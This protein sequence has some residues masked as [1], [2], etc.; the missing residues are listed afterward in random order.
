[1][2]AHPLMSQAMRNQGREWSAV[3]TS[4]KA[5]ATVDA[6]DEVIAANDAPETGRPYTGPTNPAK[7]DAAKKATAPARRRATKTTPPEADAPA[8]VAPPV[9][10]YK[11]KAF[12]TRD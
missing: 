3:T 11:L 5:T 10:A 4:S 1:M 12:T 8:Q 2:A 9:E 7:R 6:I